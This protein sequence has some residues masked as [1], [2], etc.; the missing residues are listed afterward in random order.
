MSDEKPFWAT[1]MADS[2]FADSHFTIKLKDKVINRVSKTRRDLGLNFK[3]AAATISLIAVLI[4]IVLVG[5]MDEGFPLA[6]GSPQEG[7]VNIHERKAYYDH[8]SL[9]FS[10]APEPHLKGG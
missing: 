6:T 3:V 1:Q 5:K 4:V 10:V 7:N 2:P 8:R 9:L